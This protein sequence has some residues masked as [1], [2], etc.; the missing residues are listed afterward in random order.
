[1]ANPDEGATT[2]FG[3]LFP[4]SAEEPVVDGVFF[5]DALIPPQ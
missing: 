5:L 3:D 4:E 2:I 1:L